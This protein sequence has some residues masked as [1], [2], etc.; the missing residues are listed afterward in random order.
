[1][2]FAIE[3]RATTTLS[4]VMTMLGMLV[5][6]LMYGWADPRVRQLLDALP[7]VPHA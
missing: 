6:D 5:S 3:R 1:M 2:A 4:A 7:T